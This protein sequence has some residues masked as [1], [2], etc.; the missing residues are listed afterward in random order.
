MDASSKEN[1][2]RRAIGLNGVVAVAYFLTGLLGLQLPYYAEYVTLIWVPTAVA[3]V[4]SIFCGATIA[5]GVWLGS[6]SLNL[7]IEPDHLGPAAVIAAGN[8]L[9]PVLAGVILVRWCDFRPQL[10]RLRDAVAYLVVGVLGTG[11]VTSTVGAC[12]LCAAGLAPWADFSTAWLTWIGGEAVG[13]L[14]AGPLLLSWLSSPDPTAAKSAPPIERAAMVFATAVG[15]ALVLAYGDRLVS[16]PYGYGILFLW[17]LLRSG[18]RGTTL[19][20]TAVTLVLVFGTAAGFG[21]F[22]SHDPRAEMLSLWMVL[23]AIGSSSVIAAGLIAERDR[24]LHHHSRLLAELDHRVKNTLATVVALAERSGE[25]AVDLEDFHRRFVGRVHA[26]ARTHE[27]LARSRWESMNASEVIAMTLAPF[28]DG[29]PDRLLTDGDSALLPPSKVAPLTMVFHELATN[30]A[31][32]GAWSRP[33]G[34]VDVTWARNGSDMFR[35]RW[36]EH[37]GPELSRRPAHGYGLRLVE[38]LVTYELG[39]SADIEFLTSGLVCTFDVPFAAPEPAL[40]GKQRM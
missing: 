16:L 19:A 23:L 27:G 20:T 1:G 7:S 36:S 33:R 15:S 9:G 26:I 25:D 4:A 37:G 14:I 22:L 18:L 34:R 8:T 3:L 17:I 39:G 13:S 12:L 24:A 28:A 29:N 21:P 40:G 35:F 6:L 10:D 38:G 5:P 32:Y 31:K 2:M 30:A 11:L